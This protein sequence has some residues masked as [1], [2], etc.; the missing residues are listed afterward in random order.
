M[1]RSVCNTKSLAARLMPLW[2]LLILLN[3]SI[4]SSALHSLEIGMEA[5][6]FTL[7]DLNDGKSRA[8]S[9]LKGEKLTVVLFWAT[10]GNN[11]KKALEQM[12][13]L[14]EKYKGMG[15]AVVGINVDKQEI[16]EESL[17]KIREVVAPLKITFPLL[18]DRRLA[19]FDS[20]GIIAA[21]STLI[22]DKNRVIRHELSG[23][24]LMGADKLVQFVEAAIENKETAVEAVV[25]GYQPDKKAVRLWNMGISTLKSERTAAKAKGWF[26]RAIAAD[27]AFILPYISLGTL[28]YKQQNL[29]EAKKQ[30]E[31]ALEKKPDHPVA[32]SSL[33]RM[34]LDGGDL[35]ASELMLTKAVQADE[36]YLLSYYLLGVLK[37]RQGKEAEALLWFN[38][39]EQLNPRDYK[40]FVHKGI[41]YEE[42]KNLP[43][44]TASYKKALALVIGQ[45]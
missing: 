37:S 14:H 29:L 33:G 34:L 39:A 40:L 18:V 19:T 45:P 15:L 30:F 43:A 24:P 23:F 27:P 28:Y 16:D 31:L 1:K 8:F 10:W 38:K 17:T 20:Y 42:L 44:A 26:E 21:P 25:I 13:S 7:T 22:L 12:Q 41:M 5:P 6:D 4:S 11:S 35:P 3:T 36:A 32:L 2:V 9:T